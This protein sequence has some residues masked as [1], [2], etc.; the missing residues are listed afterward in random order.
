MKLSWNSKTLLIAKVEHKYVHSVDMGE[1][2]FFLHFREIELQTEI[3]P[4]TYTHRPLLEKYN[5]EIF[6]YPVI[7]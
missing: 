2:N 5:S 7:T 1:L 6:F 4:T 3:V